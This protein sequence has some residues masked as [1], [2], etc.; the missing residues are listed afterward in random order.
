VQQEAGGE[1][2]SVQQGGCREI[3]KER[4]RARV[5]FFC[6]FT[7]DMGSGWRK[8]VAKTKPVSWGRGGGW[9]RLTHRYSVGGTERLLCCVYIHTHGSSGEDVVRKLVILCVLV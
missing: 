4:E 7:V 2:V 1:S 9:G 6:L 3:E 5:L 8:K